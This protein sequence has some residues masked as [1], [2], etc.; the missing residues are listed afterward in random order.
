MICN[1]YNLLLIQTTYN[2]VFKKL[3]YDGCGSNPC[4]YNGNCTI[5]S[6]NAY[7]CTCEPGFT[8]KN[9]ETGKI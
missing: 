8:S 2:N 5:I 3:D 7:N 4:R 6:P 9:C 1:R